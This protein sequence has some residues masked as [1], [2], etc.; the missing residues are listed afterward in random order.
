MKASS[1]QRAE[2][3]AKRKRGAKLSK[4]MYGKVKWSVLRAGAVRCGA[5]RYGAARCGAVWCDEVC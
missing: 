3:L 5:V 1:K 2:R 4:D